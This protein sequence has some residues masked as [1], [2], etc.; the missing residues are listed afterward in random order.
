VLAC[1]LGMGTVR[2]VPLDV[3]VPTYSTPEEAVRALAAVTTYA[4]W[5][6]REV[7]P[8]VDPPGRDPGAARRLVEA[9]LAQAPDG[10]ELGPGAAAALLA[11]YGLRLW[12]AVPVTGPQDAVAVAARLGYPVALK[13]TAPHLRHRVDLGGVRLDIAGPEELAQDAVEMAAR[14]TPLGGGELVVQAMAPVG[15]ACVV[16][17]VEDPLYG[18]VVSFGLGGDATDLLGDWAH[19]IAPLTTGDVHEAV[20]SVRAAPKLTGHRGAQPVDVAAVEDV[21]ARVSTLADDLPEVAELELN[22][23]VVSE[24]GAHVLGAVIRLAPNEARADAG[25]RELTASS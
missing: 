8:L 23:V 1:L 18:P 7:T 15:V 3:G 11:C 21:L 25:R 9:A 17:S 13:T 24:Q 22:P 4:G 16:R 20:R 5:R 12:P 14:L 6:A 19:R 2:D 10:V